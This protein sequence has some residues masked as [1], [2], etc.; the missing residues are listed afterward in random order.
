[1]F[2]LIAD[3]NSLYPDSLHN[4][5]SFDYNSSLS[6]TVSYVCCTKKTISNN[7]DGN[8]A[9]ISVVDSQDNVVDLTQTSRSVNGFWSN[10]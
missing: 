5:I 6:K 2:I 4:I 8:T 1:M 7:I 10:N 3:N 9:H